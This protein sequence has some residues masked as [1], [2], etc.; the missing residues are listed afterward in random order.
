MLDV[1]TGGGEVF[2]EILGRATSWP[3]IVARPN[4]EPGTQSAK[5]FNH[6]SQLR[7]TEDL[8]GVPPPGKAATAKSMPKAFNL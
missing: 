8:L 4:T 1:Q 2:A 6:S 3:S 5:L 7:T